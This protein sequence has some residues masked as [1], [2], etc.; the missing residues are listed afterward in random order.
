MTF[1]RLLWILLI[2]CLAAIEARAAP[3]PELTP[4]E[5]AW[6]A[7]HPVVTLALD[8]NN[9]PLNF[10]RVDAAGESYAGA[11]V[12]YAELAARK[13]G[14]K[15]RWVGS[16]WDQA[17]KR[18]MAHEVDGVISARERPER[19][20]KLN[21]TR[22]YLEL[23]IAMVVRPEDSSRVRTLSDFG[24]RRVAV[25]RN[26]VRIPV[27]RSRCPDCTVVEVDNPREGVDKVAA[28]LADGYFDDLPV[29]QRAL[30]EAGNK[31]VVGLL[32]Y[33]SEAATIRIALR[34]DQP[35]W[36]ALFDKALGSLTPEEHELIR[37]RWLTAA[38]GARVQRELNLAEPQRAWLNQHPVLRVG[39]D[40]SRA[41]LEWIGD[42]GKPHGIAIDMLS[43]VEEM[44]GVRFEIVVADSVADLLQRMRR[45]DIDLMA[46]TAVAPERES[47]L[48]VSQPY[49]ST[50]VVLY[51]TV[52]SGHSGGL[53]G[54]EG[55]RL[56]VVG[57][58][59][60]EAQLRHDWPGITLVQVAG[61][62]EAI[63][64]M[65]SG[66]V[67]AYVGSLL[68][69]SHQLVE[70]G[71]TD[72]RVS[73]ETDYSYSFGLGVRADW[74]ELL[75]LVDQALAQI[76]RAERDSFRRRWT[77]VQYK[78]ERDYRLIG[79]LGIAV[80][81]AMAFIFQLRRM[82]G[83]RTAELSAEVAARR[84]REAEIQAL[85]ADLEQRVAQRTAELRKALDDLQLA[86]DQ[87]VQGEK[88]ASLGRLV[89]GIAHELNT[90]LGNALAVASALKERA[91]AIATEYG[92]GA[93]RRRTADEFFCLCVESADVIERNTRRAAGLIGD[94][95]EIAV[96]QTSARRRKFQLRLTVQELV[97]AHAA[98]WRKLKHSTEL[99]IDP[100]IEMDGYPG[101][102]SQV[103]G[104]LIENARLHAFEEGRQG[105]LRIEAHRE[106]D[107]VVLTVLDDGRGIPPE[108]LNK[109]FDPFFTTR[110]GSG[111][112]GLG[113]YIVHTLVVGV[114]GGSITVSSRVG[115]GTEFRL[116]LP[117]VAPALS[118]STASAAQGAVAVP[119]AQEAGS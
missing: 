72:I 55:R 5:R 66:Q 42:D 115:L 48:K 35:E 69:G 9:A 80:L 27:V 10:R 15:L 17:L 29:S 74:P 64:L 98:A 62:R 111:G 57:D 102:L 109:I 79:A 71:A 20:A 118:E 49:L 61:L 30:A 70:L 22:P 73:A 31:L 25:V 37:S 110:M 103:L 36:L 47:Y 68:S 6:I 33:Y 2:G 56:A 32:Y 59:G 75:P 7:A 90:P 87:L 21:F 83:S 106:G 24:G 51:S 4:A 13:L 28:K 52:A 84:A 116:R 81:V 113:L 114:L 12:E 23:P 16:N 44:L 101:T 94:F 41:P 78:H 76:P 67:S 46:S 91:T 119:N 53:A 54:L 65:R 100:E 50:P 18:A 96:D 104:N 40:R 38:E 11:S 19:R 34:N 99:A 86:A 108:H 85:N 97:G 107:K 3:M 45:K 63:E 77:S 117:L 1:A 26:T 82:V 43:R 112:S 39:I 60:V 8:E 58:S 93:L 88:V 105:L 14:L 92:T 95:K 89:A